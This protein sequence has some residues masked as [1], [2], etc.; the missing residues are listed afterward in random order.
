MAEMEI[1]R[2]LTIHAHLENSPC[3]MHEQEHAEQ[4]TISLRRPNF[5]CPKLPWETVQ[6]PS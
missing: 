1:T 4:E 3:N 5:R 6:I 2:R